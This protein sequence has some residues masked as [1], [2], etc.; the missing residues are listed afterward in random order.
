MPHHLNESLFS[1]CSGEVVGMFL[2]TWKHSSFTFLSPGVSSLEAR[3]GLTFR[4]ISSLK[5]FVTSISKDNLNTYDPREDSHFQY[6]VLLF[7]H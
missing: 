2:F 7:K 3:R 4:H 6:S 5:H 1:T